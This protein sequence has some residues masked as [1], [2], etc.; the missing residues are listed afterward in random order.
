MLM[1]ALK[2]KRNHLTTAESNDSHRVTK[3]QWVV[4]AIH[5]TIG[6]KYRLLHHQVDNKLLPQIGSYSKIAYFFN[7]KF[8]K[9]LNSDVENCE[10]IIYIAFEI[11]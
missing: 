4:E 6:R 1:P 3:I 5:G 10:S 7:N 11:N 8:G 9:R 2:G